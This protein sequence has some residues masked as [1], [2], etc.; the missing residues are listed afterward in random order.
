MKPIGRRQ[1]GN[2]EAACLS[3]S[4]IDRASRG[5]AGRTLDEVHL[6]SAHADGLDTGLFAEQTS[7]RHLYVRRRPEAKKSVIELINSTGWSGLISG[8]LP[9]ATPCMTSAALYPGSSSTL[10][11]GF[12]KSGS[13]ATD[14]SWQ[15]PKV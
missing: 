10:S 11:A 12:G 9:W 6:R 14:N 3:S 4:T 5:N 1:N 13:N 7:Y 8:H 2:M 15:A